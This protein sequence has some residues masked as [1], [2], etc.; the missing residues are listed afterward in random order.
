LNGHFLLAIDCF[1]LIP[2]TA[3]NQKGPM[4]SLKTTWL[5][6]LLTLAICPVRAQEDPEDTDEDQDNSSRGYHFLLR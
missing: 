6:L 3:I 2:V 5:L 1:A 4:K